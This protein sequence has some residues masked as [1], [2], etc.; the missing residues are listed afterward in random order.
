MRPYCVSGSV[1]FSTTAMRVF[2][3]TVVASMA[4][5]SSVKYCRSILK[6]FSAAGSGVNGAPETVT[7]AC[8]GLSPVLVMRSGSF[9]SLARMLR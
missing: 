2:C 5:P 1:T 8:S 4:S 7:T 3:L 6:P 9:N